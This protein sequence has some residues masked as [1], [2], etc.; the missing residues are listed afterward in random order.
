MVT[1]RKWLDGKRVLLLSNKRQTAKRIV[2]HFLSFHILSEVFSLEFYLPKRA[3]TQDIHC[4]L[5]NFNPDQIKLLIALSVGRL[6]VVRRLQS[7]HLLPSARHVITA[8]P[9]CLP[10]T[11]RQAPGG[12]RRKGRPSTCPRGHRGTMR[13]RDSSG[14]LLGASAA[15]SGEKQ[16]HRRR[17]RLYSPGSTKSQ[18]KRKNISCPYTP[19]DLHPPSHHLRH[20]NKQKYSEKTNRDAAL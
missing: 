12:P 6:P 11:S 2:P 15:Q 16:K 7:A 20:Y 18:G 13:A 14:R 10:L 3:E 19:A 5:P 17:G 9:L 4:Q 1:Y 8:H